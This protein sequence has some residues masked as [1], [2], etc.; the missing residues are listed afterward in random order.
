MEA[1]RG[2]LKVTG[3]NLHQIDLVEINEAFAGIW[4][5]DMIFLHQIIGDIYGDQSLCELPA[6]VLRLFNMVTA[7]SQNMKF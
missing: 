5:F 7:I 3:L 1:I 6:V 2:V 4:S